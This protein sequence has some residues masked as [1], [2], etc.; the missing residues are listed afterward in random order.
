MPP[1]LAR[2][3]TVQYG[4]IAENETTCSSN[5]YNTQTVNTQFQVSLYCMQLEIKAPFSDSIDGAPTYQS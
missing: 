3:H 1:N 2:L 5:K 4:W